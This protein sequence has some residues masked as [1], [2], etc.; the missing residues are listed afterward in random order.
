[1]RAFSGHT[2]CLFFKGEQFEL[3]QLRPLLNVK[4]FSCRTSCRNGAAKQVSAVIELRNIVS[5]VKLFE[6]SVLQKAEA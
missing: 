1:M 5:F 6:T 4:T 2:V 3:E